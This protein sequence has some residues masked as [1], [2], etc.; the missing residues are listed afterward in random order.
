MWTRIGSVDRIE[1]RL[2]RARDDRLDRAC[3]GVVDHAAG[4]RLDDRLV[5][6]EPDDLRLVFRQERPLRLR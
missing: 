1:V 4:D 5:R 6:Q 2:D 3:G